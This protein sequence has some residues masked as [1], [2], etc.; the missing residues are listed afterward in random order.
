M[1]TFDT[2]RTGIGRVTDLLWGSHICE[3][4]EHHWDMLDS[5][6]AYFKAGLEDNE[7]CVWVL[8]KIWVHH[9]W[10]ALQATVSSLQAAREQKKMEIVTVE[11]CYFFEGA[12]APEKALDTVKSKLDF[13][14]RA[15][16][17]G[18]RLS[19]DASWLQREHWK[20]ACQFEQRLSTL[21]ADHRVLA[22]CTYPLAKTNREQVL[23]V[24]HSHPVAIAKRDKNWEDL[25]HQPCLTYG[26]ETKQALKSANQELT[27]IKTTLNERT[28][29]LGEM[30]DELDQISY[31]MIHDMRA[32]LRAIEGF[33]TMLRRQEKESLHPAS[34]E[35]LRRMEAAAERMDF[36]ITDVLNYCKTV[37]REL[38]LG[39]VD[40]EEL[41]GDL[42]KSCQY[43]ADITLEGIFPLVVANKAGLA[44]CFSQLL[45]NSVKFVPTGVR[46]KVRI[47]A[48]KKEG[49]VRVWVEDNGTGIPKGCGEKIFALFQR[50]HGRQYKGTGMGLAIVRK[51]VERMGAAV[52]VE[53]EVGKGS[54]FWIELKA[55]TT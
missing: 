4:Y 49:T 32:P 22:M 20:Y 46:P 25:T 50:M 33:A 12:L 54:R 1:A 52:G 51:L 47:W 27:H 40:V 39:S 9:G 41:L 6:A 43:R 48:E 14:L 31:S 2:A 55:F 26:Q 23:D 29:R 34:L 28:A 35:F 45:A 21:I 37:Q 53:S 44:Q 24:I 19:G 36:L 17:N 8:P 11:D 15:G 13:A 16:Y 42:L 18:L 7:M 30:N 3:F 10:T 5:C 38:R